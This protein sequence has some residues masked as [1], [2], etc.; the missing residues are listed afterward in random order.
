MATA[1]TLAPALNEVGGDLSLLDPAMTSNQRR[2]TAQQ[3]PI[4]RVRLPTKVS[5]RKQGAPRCLTCNT[6]LY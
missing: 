2:R 4:L 1:I 3:R 6:T 5:E